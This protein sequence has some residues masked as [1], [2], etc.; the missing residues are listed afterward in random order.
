VARP[1]ALTVVAEI[2]ADRRPDLERLLRVIRD[3]IVRNPV[4]RPAELPDTHFTRWVVLA[5]PGRADPHPPVL[6]WESNHDGATLDYLEAAVAAV[7]PGLDQL[8][9]CCRGYPGPGR[10][11]EEIVEWLRGRT[12]HAQAFYC[13]YRRVPRRAVINDV[14]VRDRLGRMLDAERAELIRFPPREIHRR[15]TARLSTEELDLADDGEG[16]LGIWLRRV[17]AG[18]ALAA[19]ALPLLPVF[20][21]IFLLVRRAE[22]RDNAALSVN[23]RPV[24]DELGHHEVEDRVM[25]NQLT[26]VVDIKPGLL[27]VTTLWIVLTVI[28]VL[29]RFF[30]V[31]GNLEGMTTIHFA[32]WAILFDRRADPAVRRHRLVFFSNYDGSWDAYLGEFIDRGS[33]GLTAIWSNTE[34]FPRTEWLFGLGARDEEAFKRWTRERQRPL[35]DEAQAWWSGIPSLTVANVRNNAWTRRRVGRRLDDEEAIEWLRRL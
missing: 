31:N 10:A 18:V 17:G 4:L 22:Q 25:Q 3:D 19:V 1:R 16:T 8:F 2:A 28:G 11:D 12:V 32:R 21:A 33:P 5:D 24:H 35:P 20:G 7:R 9:G 26:H 30:Y 6:I 29:T 23:D 15:V 13:A 34:G 27:R 14:A